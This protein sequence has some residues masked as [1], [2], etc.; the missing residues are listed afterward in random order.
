MSSVSAR[1]GPDG[2]T[3]TISFVGAA[4]GRGPCTADYAVDQL[5][6]HTAIAISVRETRS[7]QGNCAAVGYERHVNI[8][9]ASPLGNRVLVDAA[10]KGAA[11]VAP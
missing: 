1:I 2:R 11:S 5:S 7:A 9:L 3:G 4:P 6:S 10:T 8:E